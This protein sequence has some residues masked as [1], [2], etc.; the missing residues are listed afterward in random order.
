MS[1][2]DPNALKKY[3]PHASTEILKSMCSPEASKALV[4]AGLTTDLSLVHFLAQVSHETAG[5]TVF[6]ENMNYSADG[7]VKTWPYHF[8]KWTA[9]QYAHK[10]VAIANHAYDG[11]NG[12]RPNTDDGWN[13]RGRG[14]TQVT[15]RD[16]YSRLSKL[17][18]LDLVANP[19][20]VNSPEHFVACAAWDFAACGCLPYTQPTAKSK[21]G[22]VTM[23][24]RRLNGGTI[25]LDSRQVWFAKWAVVYGV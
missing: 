3:W 15:G 22:D 2:I 6:V 19:D 17:T 12:N 5:G 18:G 4:E 8:N 1:C 20:L 21:R 24:T 16:N 23:V 10:P 9:P 13:Y 14:G 7:L 25:G 11:R